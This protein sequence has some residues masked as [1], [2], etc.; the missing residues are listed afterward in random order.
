MTLMLHKLTLYIYIDIFIFIYIC[1]NFIQ[2]LTNKKCSKLLKK[3]NKRTKKQQSNRQSNIK[4]FVYCS[5]KLVF[6]SSLKNM[7][8]LRLKLT[9]STNVNAGLQVIL[10]FCCCC[11][12]S[13]HLNSRKYRS[14]HHVHLNHGLSLCESVQQKGDTSRQQSH[15]SHPQ[16]GKCL[17]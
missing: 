11:S 5:S 16:Q 12:S 7:R 3:R 8:H 17:F 10:V 1:R 4:G 15:F 14:F 9:R 2:R 6:L 13:I